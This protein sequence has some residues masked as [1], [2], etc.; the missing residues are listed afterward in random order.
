MEPHAQPVQLVQ[1]VQ[2]VQRGQP[3]QLTHTATVSDGRALTVAADGW[4][5]TAEGGG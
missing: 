3:V 1:R 5:P 2:R 4:V